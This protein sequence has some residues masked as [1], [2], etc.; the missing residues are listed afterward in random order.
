MPKTK[1]LPIWVTRDKASDTL[2]VGIEPT[3]NREVKE[4]L[5]DNQTD[6]EWQILPPGTLYPGIPMNAKCRLYIVQMQITAN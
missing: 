6:G 4:W 2:W 1:L 3:F 5:C